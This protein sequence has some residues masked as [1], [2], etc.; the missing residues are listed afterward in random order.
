MENNALDNVQEESKT[1]QKLNYAKF[2]MLSALGIF[3]FIVPVPYQGAFTI[4]IGIVADWVAVLTAPFLLQ[5]VVVYITFSS[6]VTVIHK[7]FPIKYIYRNSFLSNIFDV[8]PFWLIARILGAVFALCAYFQ[9]GPAFIWDPNTGG[10]MLHDLLTVLTYWFFLCLIALPILIN[11]GAMEFVGI[12]IR[13]FMKPLFTLPGRSSLDA[14]ASFVGNGPVGVIIT[15]KQYDEGYYTG[16]ESAVIATCFSIVSIAFALIVAQVTGIDHLFVPFYFTIIIASFVAAVICPRI[17][18]LSRIKDEYNPQVGKQ[19]KE[20]IPGDVSRLQWALRVGAEKATNARNYGQMLKDTL[21]DVFELYMNIMP[22]VMAIG[23]VALVVAEYTSIMYY[24]SYPF[25]YLLQW[26]Q[27]PDAEGLAPVMIAGFFDQFLP[28]II[29]SGL[30]SEMARFI[31]ACISVT[32]L[33]YLSETAIIILKS[34][35]PLNLVDLIV[36]YFERIIITLP[37]IVIMAHLIY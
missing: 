33:I 19:I 32:P 17:P 1:P 21:K 20:D 25:Y 23:T 26:M 30:D 35:I 13:K 34:K 5:F 10:L 31:A 8:T 16:R 2:F 11:F 12:L 6:A 27:V 3:L 9:I 28:A 29:G 4:P 7:M 22:V 18:P 36:I 15:S 37:I 24:I 14:M